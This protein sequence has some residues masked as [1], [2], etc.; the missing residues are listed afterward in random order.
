MCKVLMVAGIKK[1]HRDKVQKI[2]EVG[3]KVLSKH[4]EDGVGYAAITTEGKIYGEKWTN[5]EHAFKIHAQPKPEF[6]ELFLDGLLGE[7]A[8]WKGKPSSELV[9]GRHGHI[10]P[11]AIDH[12]VAVMLHARKATIGPKS[13]SNTHPFFEIGDAKTEDTA[14]IHN[15]GITNH[16]ALTKKYS[17]CDSEVILHEYLKNFVNYN[18][19]GVEEVAKALRGEYTVGVLS[20]MYDKN[21]VTPILDIFKHKKDL[22]VGYC[23]E[24]ETAIF[25]T[26][27][28]HL[29]E[30][31]RETG[32]VIK[33]IVKVKDGLMLRINAI[34]GERIDDLI[35][36]S[37]SV[38]NYS[39]T[40]RNGNTTG[41]NT[42]ASS[43][44]SGGNQV[45]DLRKSAQ[46]T[47]DDIE[48]TIDDVKTNFEGNH[49]ELFSAKYQ[50]PG[51]LNQAEAE[52]MSSLTKASN[53]NLRALKLVQNV[54]GVKVSV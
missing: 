24:I 35:D 43:K 13:V 49:S 53:T 25:S 54:L 46:T 4:D 44:E 45:V 20:S 30:I 1:Q 31:A 7:A 40:W 2:L 41:T 5:K 36:F 12:T 26:W 21:M 6:S 18:P 10:T 38:N 33:N 17:T 23:P 47:E 11:D 48:E 51:G 28:N 37:G 32:F 39:Q 29:E 3:A 14:I 34:T 16:E 8:E 27:D 9:Y 15:G 52:F 22:H 50:T 19:Y 42:A